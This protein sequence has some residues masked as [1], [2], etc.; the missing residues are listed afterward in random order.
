M[1]A[2]IIANALMKGSLCDLCDLMFRSSF[3]GQA[4]PNRALSGF[5][6]FLIRLFTVFRPFINRFSPFLPFSENGREAEPCAAHLC[7]APG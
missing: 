5:R 3:C 7:V 1:A 2:K 4:A 6:R